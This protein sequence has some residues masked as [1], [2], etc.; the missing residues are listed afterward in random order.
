[1]TAGSRGG[2]SMHGSKVKGSGVEEMRNGSKG[3]QVWGR[4]VTCG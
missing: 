1:M 3:E 2:R 4:G